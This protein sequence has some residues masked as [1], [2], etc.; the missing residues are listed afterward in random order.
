N[1]TLSELSEA[2]GRFRNAYYY[3]KDYVVYRDSVRNLETIQQMADIRTNY[4]VSQKQIEVDLLSQ[5]RKNQ[6]ITVTSTIVAFFLIA[7]LALGLYRRNKYINK[8]SRVLAREKNRSEH[9]LLNI[10]PEQTAR[11]LKD[12]GR[13]KSQR[14]DSVTVMFAD[15]K[16]FTYHSEYLEPEVLVE[17]V[18]F[19]FTKFDEIIDKY[20]LE[21]IKTVGDCYMC[22]GRL[23]Y[24]SQDHTHKTLLAALEMA[25][26]VKT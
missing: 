10:L 5:Q 25:E 4:E 1:L 9:L 18:D 22:A 12:Y 20:G 24:P 14:F 8:M 19:Y 13:V 3:Y 17:S 2:A 16:D 21:K 26:F 23:P 15:F 11:E 7:L 6:N